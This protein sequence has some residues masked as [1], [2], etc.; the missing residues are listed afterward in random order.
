MREVDGGLSLGNVRQHFVPDAALQI[1][2]SVQQSNDGA[3]GLCR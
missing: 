3:A 2:G 1:A